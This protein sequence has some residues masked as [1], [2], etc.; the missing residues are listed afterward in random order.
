VAHGVAPHCAEARRG[1]RNA[2]RA[3][4][5]GFSL[6]EVVLSLAILG[7][8]MAVLGEAV[9][10]AMENA[11]VARDLTDAQLYCESKMAE[12]EAGFLTTDSVSDMPIEPMIESS[13]ESTA[14]SDD[15][16]WL[17]S[18]QTEL[19]DVQG[20]VLVYLSVYQDPG[21][22]KKPVSFTMTRMFLD[23]SMIPTDTSTG[24]EM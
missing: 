18:I 10:H 13:L 3:G 23:E 22:V 9:R 17:Y 20:L 1:K 2:Q 16:G 14:L 11:R 8:S 19:I 5:T 4:K 12:L 7:G 15:T 6:L 21:T 24:E